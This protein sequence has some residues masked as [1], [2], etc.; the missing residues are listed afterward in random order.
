MPS[1]ELRDLS[2][3]QGVTDQTVRT[4]TGLGAAGPWWAAP[5]RPAQVRSGRVRS[6]SKHADH[7]VAHG[8]AVGMWSR[9][10]LDRRVRRP[11]TLMNLRRMVLATTGPP[12]PRPREASH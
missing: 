12:W 10:L 6:R 11:G 8:H 5:M 3:N 7:L 9:V 2:G 1:V 4:V